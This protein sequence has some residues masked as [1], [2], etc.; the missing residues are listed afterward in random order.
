M[1]EGL[2]IKELVHAQLLH[3]R[4][5]T[6][7]YTRWWWFGCAVDKDEIEREL[8]CMLEAGIGGVELQILYPIVADD[9][10]AGIRN[11]NYLSPEFFEYIRFAAEAAKKRGMK[12]DMMLGSSWP[13]GGP[14]VP[15]ELSAPNV[16]PYTIDVKGPCKFSYDFTTRI[17][18]DCVAC[19]I[20][21]MQNCEM[22]P[23]SIV[24]ITD[25]VIDKYLFNWK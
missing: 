12:F 1:N 22:L 5:E 17:Y 19:V 16:I 10:K 3:P 25:R 21:K 9:P 20:G 8:D 11:Q 2:G 6:R 13:Y 15:V 23:E 7:G 14:F 18:G 24:D 4:K